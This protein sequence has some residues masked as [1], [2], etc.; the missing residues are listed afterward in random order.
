MDSRAESASLAFTSGSLPGPEKLPAVPFKVGAMASQLGD[1]LESRGAG[2]QKLTPELSEI[3]AP[4][5]HPETHQPHCKD[6]C[7]S[8]EL[9][10]PS[11]AEET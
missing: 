8:A 2:D 11:G 9:C 7:F 10:L 4:V 1:Q 5:D 3:P 6:P